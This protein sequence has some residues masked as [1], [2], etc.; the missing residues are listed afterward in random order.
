MLGKTVGLSDGEWKLM[1]LLW[2]DAPRT[3]A[4]LV[5][6]LRS[7]TGWTKGTVFMMLS[8]MAEKG[9]VR[10]EQGGRSKLYYPVLKREDAASCETESFLS[11]VYGGSV[12]LMVASLAGQ[13]ALTK[14]D[15]DEL[16]AVLRDAE[17]EAGE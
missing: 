5:S 6:A 13:K 7:D 4:Q 10:Y 15:I 14:E 17:K 9:T 3:V 11:K 2:D 1:N 8:R 12:G 16:Y